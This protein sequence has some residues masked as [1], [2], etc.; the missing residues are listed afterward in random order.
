FLSFSSARLMLIEFVPSQAWFSGRLISEWSTGGRKI[1]PAA[2]SK[3][4]T[5]KTTDNRNPLAAD[6]AC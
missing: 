6:R 1:E 4:Q 2:L 5:G 3:S